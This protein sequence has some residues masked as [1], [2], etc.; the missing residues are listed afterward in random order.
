MD[1]IW[2]E[3]SSRALE[4]FATFVESKP[5][6]DTVIDSTGLTG[7]QLHIAHQTLV[8]MAIDYDAVLASVPA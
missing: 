5:D 3:Q 8:D 2:Q 6:N 7:A 1:E 4:A